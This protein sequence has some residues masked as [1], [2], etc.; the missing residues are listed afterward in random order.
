MSIDIGGLIIAV[1]LLLLVYI[2]FGTTY[3]FVVYR[4]RLLFLSHVFGCIF[5]FSCKNSTKGNNLKVGHAR[6]V[7]FKGRVHPGVLNMYIPHK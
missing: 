4:L 7:C 1:F 5:L 6:D 3:C 2:C